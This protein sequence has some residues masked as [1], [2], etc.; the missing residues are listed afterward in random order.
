MFESGGGDELDVQ[1]D[2]CFLLDEYPFLKKFRKQDANDVFTE[3]KFRI[4]EQL[5][6]MCFR[7]DF[8]GKKAV[9]A[10]PCFLTEFSYKPID[11]EIENQTERRTTYSN[12]KELIDSYIK[13]QLINSGILDV[14]SDVPNRKMITQ[15]YEI[16]ETQPIPPFW[17]DSPEFETSI[18]IRLNPNK[19]SITSTN[20]HNDST[21]F[22][23]LQYSRPTKP[24][25]LGSELMF[26]HENND[27]IIHREIEKKKESGEPFFPIEKMGNLIHEKY[28]LAKSI[29][30]G[31]LT[32]VN[33]KQSI[34]RSK[35]NNGDTVVFPDTL[36]KHAVINPKEKREGNSI[37]IEIANS[38]RSD[39][40]LTVFICPQRIPTDQSQYEGRQI[41]SVFCFI[42]INYIDPQYFGDS[43]SLLENEKMQMSVK[44]INLDAE[45]C[46]IFL[47]SISDPTGCVTIT[48]TGEIVNVKSRGGK[49]RKSR[50]SRKPRKKNNKKIANPKRTFKNNL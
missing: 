31:L 28:K 22:Q 37:H 49:K 47:N 26:Y 1:E 16:N 23:I 21:L 7:I 30:N 27:T 32:H 19:K 40:D 48:G 4:F 36:W 13:C 8:E 11:R 29:Y 38:N 33:Y 50:K 35:L 18:M 6:G 25:V 39:N 41:I 20:F 43:F 24:Y 44:T 2:F 9:S 10:T 15:N 42:C 12:N 17:K 45:Q 34:L 46:S 3:E 5:H 14:L